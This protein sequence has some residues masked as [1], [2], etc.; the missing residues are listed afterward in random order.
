LQERGVALQEGDVVV[1]SDGGVHQVQTRA[2]VATPPPASVDLIE[3]AVPVEEAVT[4]LILAHRSKPGPDKPSGMLLGLK[5]KS[6]P[7]HQ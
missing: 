4:L 7:G 3:A 2:K 5:G 1:P 6:H